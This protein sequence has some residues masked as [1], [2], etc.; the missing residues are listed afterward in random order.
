MPAYD[1]DCAA[2]G[3]RFEVIHGVHVRRPDDLPVVRQRAG[4]QGDHGGRGPLP[5]LGLG[6]DGTSLGRRVRRVQAG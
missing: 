5:G 3:R 1:Y 2:C 6:E 4:S